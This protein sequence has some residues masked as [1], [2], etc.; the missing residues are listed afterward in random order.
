MPIYEYSCQA[1]GAQSEILQKVSD[2]P[3]LECPACGKPALSKTISAPGFRLAGSG[4]Y[5]TDF[6][7][8]AKKNLVGDAAPANPGSESAPAPSA[9]ASAAPASPAPSTTPTSS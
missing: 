6:K 4:W 3:A 8:G 5:E 1:C 9:A 7:T 2:A